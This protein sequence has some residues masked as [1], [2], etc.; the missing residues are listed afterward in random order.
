VIV[1]DA[2]VLAAALADDGAPGDSARNRLRDE[3]LAAPELV[4]L[5]V[6]SVLRKLVLTGTLPRRRAELALTDLAELPLRRASHR[7]L[8]ARCWN[9]RENATV[10]DAAYVALAAALDVA[11][12][13]L[14][15]RLSRATGLRCE[16][17]LL[18]A[19]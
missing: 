7:P 15:A 16:V 10:Y 13:T 6:T 14:D 19:P 2:G 12:L 1:V 17:E 18:S 9:L 5:E 4:D 8:L 11:L 3:V